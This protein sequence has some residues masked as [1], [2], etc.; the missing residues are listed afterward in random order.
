MT[1]RR[2]QTGS[3]CVCLIS[4]RP[5]QPSPSPTPT[6]AAFN[7]AGRGGG[8]SAPSRS[9][10][11]KAPG[12][13]SKPA[14][15]QSHTHR[16]RTHGLQTQTSQA[17]RGAG[18]GIRPPRGSHGRWA[19]PEGREKPGRSQKGDQSGGR[20]APRRGRDPHLLPLRDRHRGRQEKVCLTRANSGSGRWASRGERGTRRCRVPSE[21]VELGAGEAAALAEPCRQRLH[22][23][24]SAR[25]SSSSRKGLS[26]KRSSSC[27][28]SWAGKRGGVGA[29]ARVPSP[30]SE[31][32]LFY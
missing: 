9:P 4:S 24:S 20:G 16:W 22:S 2:D 12:G 27:R 19:P 1:G 7:A 5:I 32:P 8:A 6:P 17:G 14:Q 15:T 21:T 3:F 25:T 28:R 30:S 13:C 10:R 11:T 26:P 18:A 29:R 31:L 23:G